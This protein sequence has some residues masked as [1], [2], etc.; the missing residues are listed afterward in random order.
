MLWLSNDLKLSF[1]FCCLRPLLIV[2]CP[3]RCC[4]SPRHFSWTSGVLYTR[5]LKLFLFFSLSTSSTSYLSFHHLIMIDC[6]NICSNS[7]IV[8]PREIWS[9]FISPAERCTCFHLSSGRQNT[10][11]RVIPGQRGATTSLLELIQAVAMSLSCL[12]FGFLLTCCNF[13]DVW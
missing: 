13:I 7:N 11:A 2:H 6:R 10:A 12:F 1:L 8:I 5:H 4:C 9:I 3:V